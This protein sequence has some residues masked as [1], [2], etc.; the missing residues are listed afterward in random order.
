VR[1][2]RGGLGRQLFFEIGR[3]TLTVLLKD[4][5]SA[6]MFMPGGCIHYRVTIKKKKKVIL[7]N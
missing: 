5:K 4:D 3:K 7:D 2:K 1:P 6:V